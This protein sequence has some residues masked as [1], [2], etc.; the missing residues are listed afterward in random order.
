MVGVLENGEVGG[1]F[2][3]FRL[4][5]ARVH[6]VGRYKHG[7]P[8]QEGETD[9]R[10]GGFGSS[11][12]R[13]WCIYPVQRKNRLRMQL[14]AKKWGQCRESF[15]MFFQDTGKT[16]INVNRLGNCTLDGNKQI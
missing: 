10:K 7:W 2:F 5:L 8:G 16:K 3:R 4:F 15:D 1:V 11:F 13:R 12:R 6:V 9:G 14:I